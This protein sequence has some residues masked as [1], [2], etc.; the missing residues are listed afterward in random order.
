MSESVFQSLLNTLPIGL[1]IF[2]SE[3]N[4]IHSNDY[5]EAIFSEYYRDFIVISLPD[6]YEAIEKERIESPSITTDSFTIVRNGAT[7]VF[8]IYVLVDEESNKYTAVRITNISAQK[9][10]MMK[11]EKQ[12][13][14]LLWKTRSRLT[15][16]L[17]ALEIVSSGIEMD[18][19]TKTEVYNSSRL[20]LY[21][22]GRFVDN[23]RDLTLNNSNLLQES[24]ELEMCNLRDIVSE[25]IND[26]TIYAKSI[27]KTYAI[28]NR[29]WTNVN[30]FVDRHRT[31]KIV[32]SILLNSLIYSDSGVEITIDINV[33]DKV[34]KLK[35]SDNGW[36]I[37]D[38]DQNKIF[39]YNFR[40]KNAQKSEH[41]G[42]GSELY[43]SRQLLTK[44][45][46]EI[47]FNS[48]KG[49]GSEFVISFPD[50]STGIFYL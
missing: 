46:S 43:I 23:Y 50:S 1:M 45:N 29:T 22:V 17:N 24:L 25:A 3:E 47:T 30:V 18:E 11:Q 19:D 10:S 34:I 35:I 13:T 41:N 26:F 14:D 49:E 32:E 12:T 2:D 4:L 37:D 44:M 48:K 21:Q 6:L 16:L 42:I 40:G 31:I 15:N 20:E 8:V 7:F 9:N 27:S 38:E 36:G 28:E 5:A 39:T 33:I